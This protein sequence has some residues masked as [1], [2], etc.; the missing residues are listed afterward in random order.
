METGKIRLWLYS[1]DAAFF[2]VISRAL[3]AEVDARRSDEL[4]LEITEDQ[5]GWWDV[6]LLDLQA[7]GYGGSTHS[8]FEFLARMAQ[9]DFPTPVIIV[10]DEHDR[11]SSRKAIEQGAYATMV[12]PPDIVELRQILRRAYKFCQAERELRQLRL[13]GESPYRLQNLIGFSEPMQQVFSLVHKT[14]PCDV[15]V[16]I[17]GETGTGK[18]LL[19]RAIHQLSLRKAG[20]FVA[21]SCANLPETLIEDELF[22]HEKGAFTGAIAA[23]RGRFEVADR[24]TLFLDEIGD[25]ALGLQSKLLR[26]LQERCFERLGNNNPVETNFRLLCATHRDLAAMV[27]EGKFREDLYY[28]LNVLQIHLPPLRERRDGIPVLAHHFLQRFAKEF[29][30]PV[31]RFSRSA[32]QAME[33]YEWPGNVRELENAIQRAIVL[34]E[35]PIIEISHLP[36]KLRGGYAQRRRGSSYEDEV[37]NFKRR[38]LTRTLLECG[39]CKVEAARKLGVAR[40]YLHRLITQ[41]EISP[42][43]LE[44]PGNEVGKES[45]GS[46][47][48]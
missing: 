15:T 9:L 36:D 29:G 41:L 27:A 43:E 7:T 22:G 16:L 32:L 44:G 4:S 17:T 21:F 19:A 33:E 3:G 48:M 20:P 14:A 42:D 24:G 35:G 30:K 11:D 6:I 13:Q 2:E 47:I 18:G 8:S 38:L 26:V 39:W 23:R 10:L 28:R 25:L 37:R 46:R 40:S 1:A 31:H 45:P 12:G 5:T 34:A